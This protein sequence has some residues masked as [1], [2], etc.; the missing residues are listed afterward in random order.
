MTKC[1]CVTFFTFF[2]FFAFDS[3]SAL[4]FVTWYYL[5][6]FSLFSLLFVFNFPGFLF[7]QSSSECFATKSW[8]YKYYFGE[9][10]NSF[11]ECSTYIF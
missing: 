1:E 4:P 6:N 10:V 2:A 9:M 7:H 11:P 8:Q 5:F 3:L